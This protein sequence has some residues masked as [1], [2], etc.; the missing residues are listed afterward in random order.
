MPN[1]RKNKKKAN[2]QGTVSSVSQSEANTPTLS[3][4]D[5][6]LSSITDTAPTSSSLPVSSEDT[7]SAL[8]KIPAGGPVGIGAKGAVPDNI[9]KDNEPVKPKVNAKIEPRP[10][11]E[12][13]KNS[14]DNAVG[15]RAI[16]I[17]E[18]VESIK[19]KV[20]NGDYK[21]EQV[22]GKNVQQ[23]TEAPEAAAAS[24]E[25]SN[26]Q[27]T[28]TSVG[29]AALAAPA[30]I[31]NKSNP[32]TSIDEKN[33]QTNDP[34]LLP[35]TSNV[36]DVNDLASKDGHPSTEV[37]KKPPSN[38]A[39]TKTSNA[40]TTT[41]PLQKTVA[42][43]VASTVA[44]SDASKDKKGNHSGLSESVQHGIKSVVD[45]K[46]VDVE[47]ILNS[48]KKPQQKKQEET[49]KDMPSRKS[50]DIKRPE[51]AVGGGNTPAMP[52]SIKAA[53]HPA[54]VTS[55]GKS[56]VSENRQSFLKKKNCIIL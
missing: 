10:L 34:A 5:S 44:V 30:V 27:T 54:D 21:D 16:N 25:K 50:Q 31:A 36:S 8:D 35:K 28:A 55:Q 29:S 46:A 4:T 1:K 32:S 7:T 49:P 23:Q 14:I 40:D 26:S 33:K 15:S 42:P 51:A 38:A 18:I 20:A 53:D 9:A 47:K 6:A 56:K 48:K 24:T 19:K 43:A 22:R 17:E 41:L 2:N 3:N 45:S 12:F 39:T 37:S 11:P 52:S 13:I